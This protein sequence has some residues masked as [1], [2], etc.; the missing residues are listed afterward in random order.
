MLLTAIGIFVTWMIIAAMISDVTRFIIPNRL[1][2]VLLISYPII[3]LLSPVTPDWKSSLM[4]GGG[5]FAVGFA[6]FALNLMGG[7]DVKL[8]AV[9]ALFVGKDAFVDFITLVALLGGALSILLVVARKMIAHSFI[10][11]GKSTQSLPRI[12]TVGAP[13]PYGV[14]IGLAFLIL[15]WEGHISNISL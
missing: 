10:R 11:L 15:L 14:A 13:A 4:I 3:V 8:L 2:L 7:G 1:V 6:L 9:I 12:L 5:A